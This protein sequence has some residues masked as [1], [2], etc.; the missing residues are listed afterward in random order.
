[1]TA[2]PPAETY[3]CRYCRLASDGT[4]TSCPHC[5]APVDVASRVSD[6][7]W[8]SQ[9]PIKDMAR[10]QFGQSTCQIEGTYVPGADFALR[11]ADWIYF[12]HHTL[13]WAEPSV[14]VQ[15]M[16]MAGGWD[17]VLAGMPLVMMQ[18]GGPGHLA[19]SD[20]HPGEIV[21]L[22]LA[23]GGSVVVREHR[24]LAATGNVAYRWEQSPIWFTVQRGDEED[25][26]YP[27]GRLL[28][29]F[30]AEG[31]PGLL[32]LHSPGNTFVRDL[33]PGQTICIQPS[34]LL[35][36]DPSVRMALHFEY[37]SSGV[38]SW[39]NRYSYRHVW[40]RLGGPG[41]VAMQ[42]VFERPESS[43]YIRRHSPATQTAW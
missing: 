40:L 17:R 33:G 26:E 27:L 8:Q 34:S 37:P 15:A 43:G 10:I 13:L 16:P 9:P 41:R 2:T 5:G 21:A 24:F 25:F 29:R 18:A 11:G 35:Y 32:L 30:G 19:L 36:A 3:L 7:G 39:G 1:M 22:P 38:L 20:D 4:A 6:S 42:S 23:P 14:A 31:G 12:S 28:D